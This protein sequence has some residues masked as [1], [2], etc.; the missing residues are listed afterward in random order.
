MNFSARPKQDAIDPVPRPNSLSLA[1][2]NVNVLTFRSHSGP[3]R[4]GGIQS[5]QPC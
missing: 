4:E 2:T 5:W 1:S 3:A